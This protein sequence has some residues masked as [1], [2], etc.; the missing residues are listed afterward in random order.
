M[1][2]R[3]LLIAGGGTLGSYTYPELLVRGWQVDIIDQIPRISFN[4]NLR[5]ICRSV[6][7]CLLEELFAEYRYDTIVDFIH[8]SDAEKYPKRGSLL[9]DNTDQLIFLSSYRVYAESKVPLTEDSLQLLDI[10][11]DE[12]FLKNETYAVP[13]SRNER[14]LRSSGYRN[15]TIIRP[16]ISFSHYRLDLVNSGA[17]TF[18]IRA[19]QRK[20]NLLPVEARYKTAGIG[21]AGNVGR[22]IATLCGNEK[23]LGEAFTLGA[24]EMHTWNDV[25]EIY[26]E[27]LNTEFVWVGNEDYLVYATPNTYMDCCMLYY[28]RLFDRKVDVSK[29]LEVTDISRKS[30]V[31][32]EQG[33]IRELEVLAERPDLVARFDTAFFRKLNLKMD[34]YLERCQ[35]NEGE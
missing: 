3:V 31:T 4:R 2:K 7:E 19:R 8:Y 13:K 14:W 26:R 20:K 15:W 33:I 28:D 27:V 29:V 24:G 30:L 22:M 10:C 9:L 16:M 1:K 17:Q 5:W 23:A 32:T 35:Q 18:F 6:D 25:A 34:Y 11:E 12:R 21:W